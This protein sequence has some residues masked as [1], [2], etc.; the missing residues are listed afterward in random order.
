MLFVYVW[1][2]DFSALK[3]SQGSC[4]RLTEG[5]V[6]L[7][8]GEGKASVEAVN[9]VEDHGDILGGAAGGSRSCGGAVVCV[10]LV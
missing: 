8:D 3:Y 1:L 2:S 10:A 4:R 5:I 9:A 7:F 6:Q